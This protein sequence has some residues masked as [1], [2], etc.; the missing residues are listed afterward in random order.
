MGVDMRAFSAAV[1][2]AAAA[3]PIRECEVT[4]GRGSGLIVL[5]HS[6]GMLAMLPSAVDRAA[7]LL[8]PVRDAPRKSP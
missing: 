4:K 7:V 3:L 6:L 1:P 8:E 5:S 2:A